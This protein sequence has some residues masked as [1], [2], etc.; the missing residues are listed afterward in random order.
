MNDAID[1]STVKILNAPDVRSW[2]ATAA[3]TRL[4]VTP[5]NIRLTFTKQDGPDRWPDQAFGKPED[6]GTIQY[7]VWL[8]LQLVGEWYASA[9]IECWHGRDGVGDSISDF[10]RNWYYDAARWAP[11]TGHTIAPG[12]TIGFMVTAGDA[13]NGADSALRERS[14]VVTIAAPAGDQ[15]VF[16]FDQTPAPTPAP[17]PTPEP[18]HELAPF[19][20]LLEAIH[21]ALEANTQAI[22]RLSDNIA[23]V[24]KNG[25]RIHF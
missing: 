1:L 19:L 16:T 6:H 25:V 12:E 18:D 9:F 7:T 8:F 17:A 21:G 23:T 3:I 24:G 10:P 4:E 22:A 2:P 20:D 14:N 15:G 11:M 5:D 13:R